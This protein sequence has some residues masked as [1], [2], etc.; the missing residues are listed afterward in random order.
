VLGL[1]LGVIL[2]AVAAFVFWCWGNSLSR[3]SAAEDEKAPVSMTALA[4]PEPT[5]PPAGEASE[6]GGQAP[7]Y[8]A[9]AD[10]PEKESE[11][12]HF[13]A[14]VRGM[15]VTFRAELLRSIAGSFGM[16]VSV[17]TIFVH[18]GV[19]GSFGSDSYILFPHLWM[20]KMSWFQA[21]FNVACIA[22][23]FFFLKRPYAPTLG[24]FVEP[25]ALVMRVVCVGLTLRYCMD[26]RA[27]TLYIHDPANRE[28]DRQCFIDPVQDYG[29][30][31]ASGLADASTIEMTSGLLLSLVLLQLIALVAIG[32]AL[33]PR[34]WKT[35]GIVAGVAFCATW[36]TLPIY[37]A[38]VAASAAASDYES[39]V[40]PLAIFL[41]WL[42]AI[43]RVGAMALIL[44]ST[45]AKWP[46]WSVWVVPG[47]I[48][49]FIGV[50]G[51]GV[52]NWFLVMTPS[53]PTLPPKYRSK[54]C[55]GIFL[56]TVSATLKAMGI[57]ELVIAVFLLMVFAGFI[58]LMTTSFVNR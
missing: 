50:A 18:V 49:L 11:E 51:G 41:T 20:S 8:P 31:D 24:Y 58:W 1:I 44:W 46:D 47:A 35:V 10:A 22:A 57:W 7:Q 9:Q 5:Y 21:L 52:M 27:K 13:D 45:V 25:V 33:R 53:L 43:V 4:A 42:V 39:D 37:L 12:F 55:P 23:Y 38:G 14:W 36:F 28:F 17:L 29:R 26:F 34:E 48:L 56:W 2:Y 15:A 19:Q 6:S 40:E 54:V 30:F 16:W 32:F 3:L